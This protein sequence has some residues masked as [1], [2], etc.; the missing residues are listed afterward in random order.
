[1]TAASRPISKALATGPGP[2]CLIILS[3]VAVRPIKQICVLVQL[4][5]E[6]RLAQCL[7]D[8]ALAGVRRL[9]AVEAHR[10]NDLVDVVD[11]ALDDDRRVIVLGFLEQL[12]QRGLAA[13]DALPRAAS[14]APF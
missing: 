5:L 1:M 10:P 13:V 6:E 3:Y 8:L 14:R 4:V 11:D 12:G 2:R 9:P 7:L